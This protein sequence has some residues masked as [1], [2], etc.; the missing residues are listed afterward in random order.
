MTT[1]DISSIWVPGAWALV[2]AGGEGRRLQSLTTTAN[3]IRVPK[4]FCSLR[5]GPSLAAQALERAGAVAPSI[6][7]CMVVAAQHRWWW[8]SLTS[9]LAALPR[10]NILEQPDNKGTGYGVLLGLLNIQARD[11]R[12]VVVMLP[13]DH[14]VRREDLLR[15]SLRRLADLAARSQDDVF[16]LGAEPDRPDTELGY[17]VPMGQSRNQPAGVQ[18]FVE[19]PDAARAKH[20]LKS[21]ALWN[22]FIVGGTVRALLTL[23]QP[24]YDRTV[25][26]MQQAIAGKK[27]RIP[28]SSSLE[29]VYAGLEAVD[30]SRDL[31][32]PQASL[33]RVLAV[34]QCGWND[35]GTP[36]RVMETLDQ[37]PAEAESVESRAFH[38]AAL[39]LADQVSKSG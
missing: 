37:L 12:A 23:Y 38:G 33:L 1:T 4:Q 36:K 30:F 29:S 14:Y 9:S 13:A 5:G 2:L 21:G 8:L 34:P 39:R 10:E 16:L 26:L 20:L 28:D 27:S 11:P 18:T 32:E 7:T 6:Q 15:R 31:L 17:I 24:M 35:L 3:G 25:E 22:M 19:K